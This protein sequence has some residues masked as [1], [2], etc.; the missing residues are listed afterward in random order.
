MRPLTPEQD[1]EIF[2]RRHGGERLR[3]IATAMKLPH[4]AVSQA[5]AR[6][7]L[8]RRLPPR[9]ARLPAARVRR[10]LG[11]G[12][13][14]RQIAQRLGVDMEVVKRFVRHSGL[15]RYSVGGTPLP[16]L[17]ADMEV[18]RSGLQ[19][20]VQ[21][22]TLQAGRYG[23]MIVFDPA[24]EQAVRAHYATYARVLPAGYVRV[25]EIARWR[26]VTPQATWNWLERRQHLIPHRWVLESGSPYVAWS[27]Q[28][29]RRLLTV[30]LQAAA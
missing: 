6:L 23:R 10:L 20:L 16:V 12:H 1:K 25:A 9:P 14:H 26:G 8:P 28:H 22:G 24:Q 15:D 5:F 19:A 29:V 18:T 7:N 17:A 2:K 13:T 30:P 4:T 3:E 27:A 11:Q 21:R